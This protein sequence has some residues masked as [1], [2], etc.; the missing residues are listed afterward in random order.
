MKQ[1]TLTDSELIIIGFKEKT[2]PADEFSGEMKVWEIQGLN[3]CFYFVPNQD[4]YTWYYKTTM[5]EFS[6]HVQLDIEKIA[7]LYILLSIFKIN[8]NFIPL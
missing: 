7:E 5:G 3:S 8:Y 6:N 2:Y 1:L 4:I